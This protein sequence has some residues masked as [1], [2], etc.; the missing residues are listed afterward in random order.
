LATRCKAGP[1]LRA[2]LSF[3]FS[4]TASYIKSI[5]QT[6][7]FSAA[8]S[9]LLAVTV[10]DL[11]ENPQEKSNFYLEK[12]YNQSV[13]LPSTR[14]LPPFSAPKSVIWV[15]VLWSL[16]LCISLTCAMLATL[17]QQWAN[18]YL[19]L[20][21]RPRFSL[22]NRARVREFFARGADDWQFAFEVEALRVLIQ[23][24]LTLFFAGLLIYL[25]NLNHTVF[26]PLLCWVGV[27]VMRYS[28]AVFMR[29]FRPRGSYHSLFSTSIG[30]SRGMEKFIEATVQKLSATID[31]RILKWLFE[32]PIGDN[33]R[34]QFFECIL[35]FCRSSVVEKPLGRV[36][37][38]GK[39]NLIRALQEFLESTR[40]SNYL[41]QADRIRRLVVCARVADAV[42]LPEVSLSTLKSIFAW[43]RSDAL[44]TVEMGQSL[45]TQG[46]DDQEI[47]LC[48]Q[49][50]IAGIISKT[51]RKDKRWIALAAD[52]L[53]NDVPRYL[54]HGTDNVLLA[55]LIQITAQILSSSLGGD[56]LSRDTADAS[57]LI[58]P[59]VSVFDI[60]NT[61]PELQQDFDALWN[62][63]GHYYEE[64]PNNRVLKEIHD[65]LLGLHNSLAAAPESDGEAQS[66]TTL[67]PLFHTLP[68]TH[69]CRFQVMLPQTTTRHL[70]IPLMSL[71]RPTSLPSLSK[72][73]SFLLIPGT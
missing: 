48:T 23:I 68:L 47:G 5:L 62:D 55:N 65:N 31:D 72:A 11:K 63:I 38:L 56:K 2:H 21:Q 42:G 4:H 35:G 6:G 59:Y 54:K 73:T 9:P 3:I 61:L 22:H 37:N 12:M 26:I 70:V 60:R 53:G 27:Y 20:V 66:R 24:S 15:N 45:R 51:Q 43:D 18:R 46:H 69:S 44:R 32:A 19:R 8:L 10:L 14:A 39:G 25:F 28:L 1:Y 67:V 49:S 13:G 34:L 36:A 41:S 29:F 64:E 40:S 16:S 57:S 33:D 17:H 7:L 58:L 30:L 52:H 50:I 71:C